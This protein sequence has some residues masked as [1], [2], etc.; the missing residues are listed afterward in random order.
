MLHNQG[1]GISYLILASA[2]CLSFLVSARDVVRVL[3]R[4]RS[5]K[6]IRLN[7]S[8]DGLKDHE[9]GLLVVLTKQKT[10][11]IKNPYR[12]LPI[13]KAQLVKASSRSSLWFLDRSVSDKTLKVG[14]RYFLLL[15]NDFLA[16]RAPYKVRDLKVVTTPGRTLGD[17]EI[18]FRPES[19]ENAKENLKLHEKSWH[20]DEHYE[21][22]HITQWAEDRNQEL[23]IDPKF[24]SYL[25]EPVLRTHP[26]IDIPEAKSL[27]TYEKMLVSY[28]KKINDPKTP[29][30][31]RYL[32]ETEYAK[33]RQDSTNFAPFLNQ[34]LATKNQ[35]DKIALKKQVEGEAWSQNLS[36]DE[37]RAWIDKHGAISEEATREEMD[38][39]SL[40][41]GIHASMGVNLADNELSSDF[42]NT[43]GMKLGL[44]LAYEWFVFRTLQNRMRDFSLEFS[45]RYSL[46]GVKSGAANALSSERSL[47]TRLFWYPIGPHRMNK[48]IFFVG[49][50]AR[51]GLAE[52]TVSRTSEVGTYNVTGLEVI[53]GYRYNFTNGWGFRALLDIGTLSLRSSSR[54]QPIVHLESGLSI[55]DF[56]IQLGI[57]YVF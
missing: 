15:K 29:W 39:Y 26:D 27:E 33:E 47:A 30:Q 57:S 21:E 12:Y 42:N 14:A 32:A 50:G 51:I 6:L 45:V 13:G 19:R 35:R 25:A 7:I 36:R 55:I 53:G 1:K 41:G 48:N 54:T 20:K 11:Y 23:W 2:L 40:K 4:T 10:P 18:L 49:L 28:L 46:D 9:V 31:E 16:N 37:M 43:R 56:R 8:A 34:A 3:E 52:L 24:K 22:I 44:E 38:R 5:G 17:D